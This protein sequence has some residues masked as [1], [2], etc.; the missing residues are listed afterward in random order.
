LLSGRTFDAVV[1]FAAYHGKDVEELARVLGGGAVGHYIF[2][3]TGQVYL[4]REGCPRPSKETD[5]DGPVIAR[6]LRENDTGEWDYGM[7]KRA[8]ED[9]LVKAW[10]EERFPSTRIRIP[11]VN[12]E[13]DNARRLEG[14]L[15]RFLDGGPVLVPDG[16]EKQVRHVYS[17]E[18]VRAVTQILGNKATFGEAYNLCQEEAPRIL[19]VLADIAEMLGSRSELLPMP[20][21][22]IEDAGLV[23]KGVS[24][25]SGRWASMLDPSKARRELG[26][27]HE[28]LRSYL[29]KVIAS[30]LAH[31][32]P[33]PP[34]GYARRD[35]ELELALR[36]RLTLS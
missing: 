13:R 36:N 18:V 14:Y 11:I 5:Y 34:E 19:D 4:V 8:C 6:P 20:A 33:S 25:F 30:F 35:E 7:G 32:P 27:E 22:A 29:G 16:G 17:G 9:A 31:P 12:G 24:P 21:S 28:P 10:A 26:F 2:I 15:W 3:S 1:D 23:L